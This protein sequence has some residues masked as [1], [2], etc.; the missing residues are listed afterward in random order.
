MKDSGIKTAFAAFSSL[1]YI[2]SP[3]LVE[4]IGFSL[5]NVQSSMSVPIIAGTA[6]IRSVVHGSI[7]KTNKQQDSESLH[8][9]IYTMQKG[10]R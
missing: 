10:K 3:A 1:I 9:H 5:A 8:F 2:K 4:T 6:I 7:T